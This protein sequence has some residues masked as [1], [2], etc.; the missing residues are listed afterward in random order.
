MVQ[1]LRLQGI[2]QGLD[3]MRL[4]DHLGKIPGAVFAGQNKVGH[5]LILKRGP[6]LVG[7]SSALPRPP[8]TCVRAARAP[9]SH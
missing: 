3:H 7:L 4:T 9:M 5:G 6:G 2:A 8:S 1:A